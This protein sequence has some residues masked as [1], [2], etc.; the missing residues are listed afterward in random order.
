M[1]RSTAP[2][3]ALDAIRSAA[4]WLALLES[5]QASEQDHERLRQWRERDAAHEQAWQKAQHL[6]QRFAALPSGLAMA[7]LDRPGATRRQVL[8]GALGVLALL[9]SAWLA[10]RQWP[11]ET[12]GTDLRT[13]VG[14][15]SRW[16][17]ADGS[18]LHL[19]TDSAANLDQAARQVTLIRG[20]LALRVPIG[21][22]WH[23]ETDQ[24]RLDVR[25]AD[26]CVRLE[27]AQCRVSVVAG[28]VHVSPRTGSTLTLHAGQQ[29]D[30][31]REGAGQA[32]T[33][34]AALPGWREAVLSMQDQPLGELLRELSRY[35]PGLLRWDPALERLRVTGSFRLDDTDRVLTLLAATLPLEVQ[36]RTR[37]WVTLVPRGQGAAKKTT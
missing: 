26:V 33:F 11:L 21:T 12:W 8:K 18:V 17:L 13:A 37:Y 27:G 29:V 30:L 15:Q 6:R 5:G 28:S 24:G 20:E 10:N 23:I 1:S 4:R 31:G 2:D 16:V 14:E 25:Q 34:D 19:N 3:A 35:R 22:A 36:A 32:R 7:T 9:P